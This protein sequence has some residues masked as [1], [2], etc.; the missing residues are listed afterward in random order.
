MQNFNYIWQGDNI[1]NKLIGR[2]YVPIEHILKQ[3]EIEQIDDLLEQKEK[4]KIKNFKK[5]K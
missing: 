2:G 4:K 5:R 3:Y 1:T